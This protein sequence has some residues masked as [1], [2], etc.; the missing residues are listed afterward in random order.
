MKRLTTLLIGLALGCGG[1]GDADVDAGNQAADASNSTRYFEHALFENPEDC[2]DDLTFNC[3][4][5][6]ELCDD[7]SAHLL[8]TDIMNGGTYVED[9]TAIVAT[10]DGG[11][12]PATMIFTP[13]T[14]G[15]TLTD[16]WQ[17]WE[18]LATAVEYSSCD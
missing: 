12:V 13:S 2:P 18:W 6:I 8:V 3:Y 14:D 15:R 10:F 16:D 9:S 1:G 7:G 11:D 5:G 17:T 4:P